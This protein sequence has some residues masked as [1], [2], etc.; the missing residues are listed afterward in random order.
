MAENQAPLAKRRGPGKPFQPG[1]SGN[2][3][4]KPKGMI[5]YRDLCREWGPAI[6]AEMARIALKGKT[7]TVRVRAG[8]ILL[9]RGFGRPASVIEG[10]F[11]GAD[12][13]EIV[14]IQVSFVVPQRQPGDDAK[15]VEHVNGKSNGHATE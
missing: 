4:G 7:E 6:I 12:G 2:P 9:D 13:K 8:E 5:E 1:K 10:S 14:G 15:I 3:G 11:S